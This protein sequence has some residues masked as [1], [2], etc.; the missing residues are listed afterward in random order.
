VQSLTWRSMIL[1]RWFALI[2]EAVLHGQIWR[3]TTYDFLHD[4]GEI[5]HLVFNMWLLW[6]AGRRVQDKYGSAEFLAFYLVAG[7]LSGAF[8][9]FWGMLTHSPGIAIGASGAAVAVMIVYAMNWPHE[10]W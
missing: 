5:W 9:M 3:L 4:T 8:F 2:P 6:L 10:K 1:E 7:I